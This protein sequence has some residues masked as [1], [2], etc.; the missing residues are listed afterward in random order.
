MCSQSLSLTTNSS[1]RASLPSTCALLQPF[2]TNIYKNRLGIHRNLGWTEHSA[3]ELCC[4]PSYFDWSPLIHN[5]SLFFCLGYKFLWDILLLVCFISVIFSSFPLPSK[6]Q[7]VRFKR[8]AVVCCADWAAEPRHFWQWW[9]PLPPT[10]PLSKSSLSTESG[11][12]T[13]DRQ[14]RKVILP[15]IST[16][17]NGDP[18]DFVLY[19][20]R[21]VALLLAGQISNNSKCDITDSNFI[22]SSL[23]WL[24]AGFLAALAYPGH[25]LFWH[26]VCN[27]FKSFQTKPKYCKVDGVL[28]QMVVDEVADTVMDME[29]EKVADMVV[30]M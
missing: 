29:V 7:V 26:I 17:D 27:G 16:C 25:S 11:W 20:I 14:D 18:D 1:P 2:A 5:F 15:L 19:L 9:P 24:A 6:I 13:S 3:P 8:C 10:R 21:S 4:W 30:W 12:P 23:L 22:W 28:M